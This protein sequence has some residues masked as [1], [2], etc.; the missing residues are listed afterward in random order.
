MVVPW[1]TLVWWL[2]T[3]EGGLHDQTGYYI[4]IEIIS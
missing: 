4:Y 1:H 3:C 2:G